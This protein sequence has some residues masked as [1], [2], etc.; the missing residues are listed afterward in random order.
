MTN[1]GSETVIPM[2]PGDIIYSSKSMSTFLI[3][4]CGIVGHD[5]RIYH[6]HPKGALSDT[7]EQ[8][9]TRHLFDGKIIILR[10]QNGANKV[11][12]WAENN[13]HLVKKYFF[14][15]ELSNQQ[16]NYCSKFVWQAFWF[17]LK[18]DITGKGLAVDQ[19]RWIY[20]KSI[21][22]AA[23]LKEVGRWKVSD[24]RK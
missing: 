12:S 1:L 20:P 7:W 14:T 16:S 8:Y 10:P 13:I 6:A 9:V 5:L 2:Q 15:R 21:R 24:L 22:R 19:V 18:E 17:S 11:A 4:H 23:N 3:G